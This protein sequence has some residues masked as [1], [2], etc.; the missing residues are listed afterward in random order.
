M[1]S[2]FSRYGIASLVFAIA[3]VSGSMGQRSR[4]PEPPAPAVPNEQRLPK[5][6]TY[7]PDTVEME[8]E[9]RE[10][11]KLA[12]SVPN[13]IEQLRKGLLPRDAVN[14]LKRIEKLSKHLRSQIR[15]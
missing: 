4:F 13:D 15:P 7:R 1:Q 11:S 6:N 2:R 14:K 10:L 9:A 5:P 8:R 3:L 12:A